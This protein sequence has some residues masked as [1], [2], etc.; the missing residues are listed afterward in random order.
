[1]FKVGL[2]TKK[3]EVNEDLFKQYAEA[4]IQAMEIV[5]SEYKILP[6]SFAECKAFADK[7]GIE[8]LSAHFPCD[9]ADIS[10]AN[11]FDYTLKTLTD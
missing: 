2:S 7:Y 3:K 9:R 4:G 10:D 5:L 6:L 8:I 1:M 11:D